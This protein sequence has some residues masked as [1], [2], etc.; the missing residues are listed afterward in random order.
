MTTYRLSPALLKNS[1]EVGAIELPVDWISKLSDGNTSSDGIAV[2]T[3]GTISVDVDLFCRYDISEIRYYYSGGNVSIHTSQEGQGWQEQPIVDKAGYLV[4]SGTGGFFVNTPR[5]ARIKHSVSTGTQYGYEIE[6]YNRDVSQGFGANGTDSSVVVDS[7][8]D[9]EV[10]PIQVYNKSGQTRNYHC[11]IE[12]TTDN[13]YDDSVALSDS[14]SGSFYSRYEK[15]VDIPRDFSWSTGSFVDTAISGSSII[16][17]VVSGTGYYSPIFDIRNLNP[18]RM[19]WSWSGNSQTSVDNIDQVDDSLTIGLR[20]SGSVPIAPWSSGV[21][22][23]PS[24]TKW[25]IVDGSLSFSPVSNNVILEPYIGQNG[26]VQ[27]RVRLNSFV[28]GSSPEV[29]RVGFEEATTIS[30]IPNMSYGTVY[31]KTNMSSY[32]VGESINLLTFFFAQD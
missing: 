32:V 18:V 24:D 12:E 23:N 26:Y 7:N 29:S 19:Y 31:A 14:Y 25:N 21:L 16:L 10:S 6:V 2:T 3:T 28:S 17:S 11:F 1:G 30:G 22:A 27:I 9:S 8:A 13:D 20:S 5:F 4:T 15:G